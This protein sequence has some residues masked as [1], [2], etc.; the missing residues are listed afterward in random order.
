MFSTK[1]GSNAGRRLPSAKDRD[2]MRVEES[3]VKQKKTKAKAQGSKNTIKRTVLQTLPYEQFVSEYIML[4]KSNV[5][6][7]KQTANLYSKSYLVPDFNY[8]SLPAT[9]K[10][11][12]LLAYVDLLNGFDSAASVQVT[13][14]N[15]KINRKD[16]EERVLLRYT[17]DG[18]D[19]ER[20]EFNGILHDRLMLGQNGIQCKKYITITV[21]AIDFEA[22]NTKFLNYESH[23][24]L[25]TQKLGTEMLPL[26]ANER[27]RI[28]CDIFRGVNTDL[29]FITRNEFARRSEKM[30]CCPEYFEFKKDYF[31][32][33]DKYARCLYFQK[34]PTSSLADTIFKDIIETNQSL[35]ITKNIE[36]VD[37][38]D[39]IELVRRQITNMK[40]EE[41]TKTKAAANNS[42]GAF[43]DPIEGTELAEN[44]AQAYEFLEDLQGRN[45][46]MTL[47]Q[48]IIMVTADSHEELEQ[49]TETLRIIA[50]KKQIMLSI[51]PYRQEQAFASV[52]PLGNSNSNDRER[53]LQI[54]RTLSSESTAV[55]CPFN[56]M[57]L[58][59][60]G[61]LYYGI[62]Q[63]TRSII[64]FDRRRLSNPNG[65][66]F[67]VPGAGKGVT[68]KI[69]M[70][71]SILATNDEIIIL[72]PER[73]YTALAELFG[74]EVIKI[75]ENSH[76]HINPLDLT[77][78][79]DP[80]DTSY[81]PITAKLDFLLSFFSAIMGNVE[82]QPTQKTI[83]DT[84]MREIYKEHEKPTL[85][86]YYAELEKLEKTS[87][88][89][90]KRTAA[91]LKHALHL[92]VHG[93]MNVFSNPSNVNINKRIVVYDIK[94]LGKSMQ[95]LGMMIVLENIW[96]R[97]AK[98]R[99]RGIGTRIYIDEMYLMFKSEQCADFFYVLYKRARKWGGIPTGITQN[100]DDLLQSKNART[101]LS[102]TKFIIMLSQNPT[103]SEVLSE[104]LKIPQETMSYVTNSGV[105]RGLIFAGEY[106]NIPFDIRFPTDGSA[107][108]LYRIISTKFGE[109]VTNPDENKNEESTI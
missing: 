98:N 18:N 14:H 104:I 32:F 41:I 64:L 30:L 65:F 106:G 84:V 19:D 76:T 56:A 75:S 4:V 81:D 16:F 108:K 15:T 77:E 99:S 54:R 2:K 6:I 3:T 28:L 90:N 79:P 47:C 11:L 42:R 59:H 33:N 12:K 73:E 58:V 36:F 67:G 88:G 17:N 66:I 24:N 35:I 101:M 85:K 69:E 83:I 31:M 40:Q 93:S 94:D 13:L 46:K 34:L 7:G 39:A 82:I 63:M 52:L 62:N 45:Q 100:V 5:K 102:N 26:K 74:G 43:I 23:L 51:A 107:Q 71:Y 22:A 103:D 9:E 8:S 50:R 70:I 38:A 25:C 97:V 29:S 80:S 1:K 21:P 57:E 95:T 78:N 86:E 105:G 48:F 60:E 89:E 68:A 49:N 109:N 72:D 53:N 55:F 91:Y 27:V 87:E 96:D 44:K 37:T 10:E 61:G 92:Y 20:R